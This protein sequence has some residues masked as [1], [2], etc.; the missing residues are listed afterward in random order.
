MVVAV[1]TIGLVAVEADP[2]SSME[3]V[4]VAAAAAASDED[5][6]GRLYQR[7]VTVVMGDH[8]RRFVVIAVFD[9]QLM[10]VGEEDDPRCVVVAVV[11][12]AGTGAVVDLLS[13][14]AAVA[15]ADLECF[16]K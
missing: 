9:Y 13:V 14:L 3:V 1:L 6:A 4:V 16:P 5:E 11:V 7:E 10:E 2:S 8:L 15:A 12:V